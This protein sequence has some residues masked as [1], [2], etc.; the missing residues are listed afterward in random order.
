MKSIQKHRA[1]IN[2]LCSSNKPK[3]VFGLVVYTCSSWSIGDHDSWST[4]GYF[5]NRPQKSYGNSWQ[6]FS[7]FPTQLRNNFRS[8]FHS[9]NPSSLCFIKLDFQPEVL[10]GFTSSQSVWYIMLELYF[11]LWNF[12]LWHAWLEI[13]LTE[14][15]SINWA[16]MSFELLL[17]FHR[18]PVDMQTNFVQFSLCAI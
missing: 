2:L 8:K 11:P 16:K 18:R 15:D 13:P 10:R 5:Q 12:G 3:R 6:F 1:Y 14:D 9:Q 17:T 4:T 7:A